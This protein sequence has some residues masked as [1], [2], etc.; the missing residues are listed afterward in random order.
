MNSRRKLRES[1]LHIS[2]R[3]IAIV[4]IPASSSRS[5]AEY[6]RSGASN[7]LEKNATRTQ[8]PPWSWASSTPT[9]TSEASTVRA[10]VAEGSGWCRSVAW[11][12]ASLLERNA[13]S[14]WSVQVMDLAFP[15]ADTAPWSGARAAAILGTNLD[16]AQVPLEGNLGVWNRDIL[17]CLDPDGQG[18]HSLGVTMWPR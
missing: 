4:P 5:N 9:A 13:A 10:M 2:G 18:Q 17:D 6:L 8:A 16:H 15:A 3:T 11:P 7:F 1:L 14:H 12:N